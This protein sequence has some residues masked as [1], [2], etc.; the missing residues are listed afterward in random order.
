[1]PAQLIKA[2]VDLLKLKD[3]GL[4]RL[5]ASAMTTAI[6]SYKELNGEFLAMKLQADDETAR[7]GL[8]LD[9]PVAGAGASAG[10]A[11][12]SSVLGEALDIEQ[13][14]SEALRGGLKTLQDT[15]LVADATM[16]TMLADRE[17]LKVRARFLRE[18]RRVW[19][20][21]FCGGSCIGTR[22]GDAC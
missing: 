19:G 15:E 3:L 12:T 16:E 14:N 8:G 17:R 4:W 1:M 2:N 9:K 10:G 5:K 21:V 6:N 20:A 11:T 7:A 13:G 18:P 22:F